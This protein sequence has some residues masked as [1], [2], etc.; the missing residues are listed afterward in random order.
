MVTGD[1]FNTDDGKIPPTLDIGPDVGGNTVIFTNATL[2]PASI[3]VGSLGLCQGFTG[4]TPFKDN[5]GASGSGTFIGCT[6]GLPFTVAAGS[7]NFTSF[8][9]YTETISQTVTTTNT[10]LT[11]SVYQFAA[12]STSS[13]PEPGSMALIGAGIAGILAI[14]RK[15][16]GGS[17]VGPRR[18]SSDFATS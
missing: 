1:T 5:P 15:L 2:G 16:G 6:T 7:E 3:L 13:V 12:G 4:G 14:R 8:A 10:Y 11:T 9:F 18:D 17:G